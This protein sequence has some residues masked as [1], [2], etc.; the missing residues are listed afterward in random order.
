[1]V[2]ALESENSPVNDGVPNQNVVV[3]ASG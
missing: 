2:V 3:E 1:V